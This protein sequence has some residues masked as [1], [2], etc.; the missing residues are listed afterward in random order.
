MTIA[1]DTRG[2]EAA[3]PWIEA[4]HA[5]HPSLIDQA[6]VV[7][8]LLGIVNV[9]SGAWIDESGV[10]VRPPEPASPTRLVADSISSASLPDDAPPRRREALEE[11]KRIRFEPERYVAAL[12]DWVAHGSRSRFAL[13]PDEVVRR[14]TPRSRD[15]A[16]AV[17]HFELAQHL[18]RRGHGADAI[19]HFREA[20][21]RQ[22][23]NWTYKRQAWY[24][25]AEGRDPRDVYGSDWLRR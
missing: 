16:L 3:R 6:H 12:R 17:A 23:A 9:P 19:A 4:A 25:I 5:E 14:S 10:L 8:S 13:S 20:L 22:P 1:L 21:A 2:M 24:L 15:V 18:V 7:D 11:A